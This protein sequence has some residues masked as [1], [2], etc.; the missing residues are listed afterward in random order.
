[1]NTLK[2]IYEDVL[3]EINYY[4]RQFVIAVYNKPKWFI[5]RGR[6]GYADCDVWSMHDYLQRI[7][8][9][10]IR[11]LDDE[12]HGYATVFKTPEKY[13]K[14]L[15]E[16]ALG[17][18]DMNSYVN[19]EFWDDDKTNEENNRVGK[20]LHKEAIKTQ[21]KSLELFAKYFNYLWD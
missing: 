18:D 17:F 10:M 6:R 1:M 2:D 15:K 19:Y 12:G 20:K 13:S 16:M 14:T 21:K 3:W 11:K 5:Q 9:E 8:P 7:I 4:W